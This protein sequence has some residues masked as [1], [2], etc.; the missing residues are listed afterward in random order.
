MGMRVVLNYEVIF[1]FDS[2][3]PLNPPFSEKVSGFFLRKN[4]LVTN[5][6]TRIAKK[7]SSAF[8][9]IQKER[10][11]ERESYLGEKSSQRKQKSFICKTILRCV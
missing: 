7:K 1:R 11:R 2:Q 10:E 3:L 4:N 5:T 8:P 6:W 9:P